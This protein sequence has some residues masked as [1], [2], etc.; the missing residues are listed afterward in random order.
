[1]TL[2][3]EH[4]AS[5]GMKDHL[6]ID[7]LALRCLNLHSNYSNLSVEL[8]FFKDCKGKYILDNGVREDA[9]WE[10]KVDL[11]REIIKLIH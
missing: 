8:K 4:V 11:L 7:R 10:R 5:L 1:M 3:M 6:K 9:K 2:V